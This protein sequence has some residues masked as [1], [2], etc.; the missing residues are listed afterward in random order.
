MNTT[1]LKIFK[2]LFVLLVLCNIST[3][4]AQMSGDSWQ[5][6]QQKGS[7]E[8]TVAYY[9]CPGFIYE[10]QQGK[11]DGIC[12]DIMQDF[13]DYVQNKYGDEIKIKYKESSTHYP[14]FLKEVKNSSSGVV[15]IGNVS[16]TPERKQ[17]LDFTN[18]YF[19][20]L[21]VLYSHKSVPRI[22][23]MESLAEELEGFEMV[24]LKG[25]T[26][27]KLA[28][29]LKEEYMPELK[30]NY[31]DSREEISPSVVNNP[32]MFT[33]ADFTEYLDAVK[34]G[35]PIRSHLSSDA[36]PNN[37][38]AFALPQNSDWQ[39]IINEFLNDEYIT[40]TQYR[41]IINDEL[42]TAFVQFIKKI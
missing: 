40:S 7:G 8:L 10:N 11:M 9:T 27:E 17:F 37:D 2:R 26:Y 30:I 36:F 22:G 24:V 13:K 34:K 19:K 18:G 15:G 25:T 14:D 29:K 28:L 39:P 1:L 35:L 21:V 41:K 6:V 31:I 16:V 4:Y 20:D 23:D 32:K 42:G 3:A 5:N 38:L 33:V 12:V